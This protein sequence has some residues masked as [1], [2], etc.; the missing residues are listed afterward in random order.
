MKCN[1]IQKIYPN[2]DTGE[3]DDKENIWRAQTKL[4][5][6]VEEQ[7]NF[8][9]LLFCYG[10]KEMV[11]FLVKSVFYVLKLL[12]FMHESNIAINVNVENVTKTKLMWIW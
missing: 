9:K 4:D 8:D 6:W 3:N 5:A 2:E 7:R 11:R 10:N 12:V 1:Q